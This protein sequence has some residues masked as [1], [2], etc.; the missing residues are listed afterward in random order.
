MK[1]ARLKK[2]IAKSKLWA[3]VSDALKKNISDEEKVFLESVADVLEYGIND[4][5]QMWVFTNES[6][7]VPVRES[8]LKMMEDKIAGNLFE[9]EKD[10]E[11]YRKYG[12]KRAEELAY[13]D[14]IPVCESCSGV[15]KLSENVICLSCGG[16]GKKPVDQSTNNKF[17][18]AERVATQGWQTGKRISEQELKVASQILDK[19]LSEKVL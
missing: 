9:G 19:K 1:L 18:S 12:I 16:T 6:D 8:L 10:K 15:G 14:S 3:S 13:E 2:H 7:R 17:S 4:L 11:W 5:I